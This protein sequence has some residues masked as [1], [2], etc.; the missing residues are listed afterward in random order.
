MSSIN[1]SGKTSSTNLASGI[2]S[3]ITA[4]WLN[5]LPAFGAVA[6]QPS[7]PAEK[8]PRVS[9]D[10][11]VEQALRDGRYDLAEKLAIVHFRPDLHCS[12][13]IK[14]AG[15]Q[16]RLAGGQINASDSPGED[17]VQRAEAALSQ[18]NVFVRRARTLAAQYRQLGCS[19][20]LVEQVEDMM[21]TELTDLEPLRR[22]LDEIRG[23]AK[24]LEQLMGQSVISVAEIG[25]LTPEA[26]LVI[27]FY[28][29]DRG[30]FDL[31]AQH[32]FAPV[33][34][35]HTDVLGRVASC[36]RELLEQWHVAAENN[37]KWD[38]L[39]NKGLDVVEALLKERP[40]P[41]SL[42]GW[43]ACL[44]AH[45]ARDHY[46]VPRSTIEDALRVFDRLKPPEGGT[47]EQ[48]LL[49]AKLRHERFL[50]SRRAEDWTV[51]LPPQDDLVRFG[52]TKS[53][54]YGAESAL[55]AAAQARD[56]AS[57]E[58]LKRQAIEQTAAIRQANSQLADALHRRIDRFS[59]TQR[60]FE[61]WLQFAQAPDRRDRRGTVLPDVL[62]E[63][64]DQLA[65]RVRTGFEQIVGDLIR[66]GRID[67][68]FRQTQRAKALAVGRT[69]TKQA[70]DQ[71]AP[72]SV[73]DLFS[74][75]LLSVGEGAGKLIAQKEL[76][77]EYFF[78]PTRAWAFY[79]FAPGDAFE[80][81]QAVELNR[82]DFEQRCRQTIAAL[83][84]N[85]PAGD[86]EDWLLA[87]SPRLSELWGRLIEFK[88]QNKLRRAVVA[89]D[90]PLC[91][92]PL[93]DP[94]LAWASL[95]TILPT[96]AVLVGSDYLDGWD[97]KLMWE[98]Q[99]GDLAPTPPT[100]EHRADDCT[101]TLWP[102]ATIP[103]LLRDLSD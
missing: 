49:L 96:A 2:V 91:Y 67:D 13:F 90:G 54:W 21:R 87:G 18:V 45:L 53:L 73:A 84:K 1:R 83:R 92:V 40:G 29:A 16:L 47:L 103:I 38:N 80:P 94:A 93:H 15:S 8:T 95:V 34:L 97:L 59:A 57:A 65:R 36:A 20:S 89:P 51:A 50:L 71:P 14:Q 33:Q 56:S 58:D 41:G 68:A 79:A 6:L 5:M 27:G 11:L 39:V 85:E 19:D 37:R 62:L 12:V 72:A 48:E 7:E 64:R 4:T 76:F 66:A 25:R 63:T 70:G 42:A 101:I 102:G 75:G 22:R 74:A 17:Q 55:I 98:T 30:D 10:T 43:L 81:L 24:S 78:G 77:I 82:A 69:L 99:R 28:L 32:C 88:T 86:V 26:R 61:E 46:D 60:P 23:R 52:Q 44:A 9:P 3:A 35:Q 100:V 31:A